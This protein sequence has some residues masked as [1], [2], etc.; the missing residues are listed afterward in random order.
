MII[1][2]PKEYLPEESRVAA[3]PNSVTQL[4]KLGFKVEIEAGAGELPLDTQ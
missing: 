4:Q 1:G 2:I 3:T